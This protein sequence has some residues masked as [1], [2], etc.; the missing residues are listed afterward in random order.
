MKPSARKKHDYVFNVFHKL[1]LKDALDYVA[2]GESKGTLEFFRN[3]TAYVDFKKKF[4]DDFSDISMPDITIDMGDTTIA[5]P[6]TRRDTVPSISLEMHEQTMNGLRESED[7]NT[8]HLLQQHLYKGRKQHRHRYSRSHFDVNQ[9]ENEVQEIFQ[10]TMRNRLESFKSAKMGVAPPKPISKHPK[11]DA[12]QKMPNGK[13][14]DKTRS[15]HS[16]DEDFEFSEGDSASG[17]AGSFPRVTYTTGAGIE[18]PAFMPDLDPVAQVQIPPWL[19]EG[20]P[21]SITGVAPSQRAQTG[22]PWTPSNLRRLAPL[23]I[24][25]RSTDSFMLADIPTSSSSRDSN[26]LPPPP[27]PPPS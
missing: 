22:L 21:D 11:K 14:M 7:I 4:G 25:T 6:Y 12:Q 18:N 8:H 3:D 16:G 10:R 24:S 1:N 2:E 5:N 15:Y 19:A 13:S 20:E 23:R 9:D 27:S 17:Y 26:E